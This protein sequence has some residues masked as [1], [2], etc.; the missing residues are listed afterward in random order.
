LEDDNSHAHKAP[1]RAKRARVS[2]ACNECR[3]K[4][5]RCDGIQPQCGPC[6]SLNR[7]CCFDAQPRRRGLPTGYVRAMEVL[8]GLMFHSIDGIEHCATSI[9]RGEKKLPAWH[10]EQPSSSL[11]N[12]WADSWRRSGT[13]KEL[14]LLLAGVDPGDEC[15]LSTRDLYDNLEGAFMNRL[16]VDDN[17]NTRI[18]LLSPPRTTPLPSFEP[19]APSMAP[20]TPIP[21]IPVAHPTPLAPLMKDCNEPMDLPHNWSHL[22]ERYFTDTHT[23]FP[24]APKH[25]VLRKAFCLANIN[26]EIDGQE[27]L[28]S[29]GDRAALFATLA[30][31]CYRDALS[32]HDNPEQFGG[33]LSLSEESP[34]EP[35]SFSLARRLQNEATSI[36]AKSQERGDYDYG[37]VQALLVLTI[38]QIDQGLLLQAWITVGQAV[39][40]AVILNIIPASQ[41][42]S[43]FI[44]DDKQRRLFLGIYIL[45]TLIAYTL[46]RRPYLG[47]SDLAKFGPLPVDSIEEWEAW[48][49]LDPQELSSGKRTHTPGRSL[50]T[51]N[52]FLDLATLLN[53]QAHGLTSI[54][55]TLEHFQSWRTTQP[56]SHRNAMAALEAAG[57]DTPPQILN[58][59]L[60]SLSIDV[61]LQIKIVLAHEN[62]PGPAPSSDIPSSAHQS[63]K[64]IMK[65][66]RLTT[67]SRICPLISVYISMIKSEVNV[68]EPLY[69]LD[70]LE[71]LPDPI[72]QLTRP[73]NNER[74]LNYLQMPIPASSGLL[75]L[76]A[77]PNNS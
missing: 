16:F 15:E 62:S 58:L 34:E 5:E 26:S 66:R 19:Q 56:S 24:V 55:Q 63:L 31:A 40:A 75:A 44:I 47:R 67:L 60:A 61:M 28:I 70:E 50:S 23:W 2:Q 69:A 25:D 38:L 9:L 27:G 39:Y 52:T 11:V 20:E 7:T 37:H 68:R 41:P 36:L 4:K 42:T 6:S 10:K 48:R 45:E 3:K 14:E 54:E 77:V 46:E 12:S 51:F 33:L 1:S 30:Y 35:P 22:L 17:Y 53:N 21:I 65:H 8:L 73:T 29:N 74:S 72:D 71:Q 49:S 59:I 57:T 13:M 18:E 32:F 43:G 64:A 76:P